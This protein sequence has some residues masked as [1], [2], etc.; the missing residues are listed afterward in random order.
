MKLQYF[1]LFAASALL[2]NPIQMVSSA[3]VKI[4]YESRTSSANQVYQQVN[5]A[6]VTV[7]AGREIGSGSIVSSNGRD[8]L[9]ITNNHVVR[10]SSQVFVRTADGRRIPGQVIGTDSRYDLA[11]IQLNTS[12]QLPTVQFA[13]GSGIQPGQPVIAIGSPYGRPG[14]MT[15]GSFNSTRGNGDL[16]ASVVLRPGNSGGPLLNSQGQMIGVNKAILES[17]RGANTGISIATSAAI[18]Q[19]FVERIRPGSTVAAAP[20][21]VAPSNRIA[22]RQQPP[23]YESPNYGAGVSGGAVMPQPNSNWRGD[24]TAPIYTPPADTRIARGSGGVVVIPQPNTS[25]R[26]QAPPTV[27]VYEPPSYGAPSYASPYES[28]TIPE[29][30]YPD[31]FGAGNSEMYPNIAQ[32][33]APSGARLGVVVDTRTM[34]IQQVEMGSAA[35]NSGL[36]VGDRLVGVNGSQLRSF[37]DLQLF[38]N[39]APAAAAFTIDRGGRAA[40]V[41]VRF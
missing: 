33:P 11:L 29:A 17:A 27:P 39:Q 40:T 7:F 30:R 4:A 21:Q 31:Q 24:S 37:D 35:A 36:Q 15:V 23:M 18:A 1:L 6:V 41:Q 9:V 13:N 22:N 32:A 38:M 20:S 5:P 19:Q 16:Q 34:M 2:I 14:V 25:S 10:G 28:Q 12:E 8:N 3:P 26:W